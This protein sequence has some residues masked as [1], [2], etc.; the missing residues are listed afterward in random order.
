MDSKEAVAAMVA[1]HRL[2]ADALRRR[3][4]R[5]GMKFHDGS[6]EGGESRTMDLFSLGSSVIG[7]VTAAMA[8]PDLRA[9]WLAYASSPPHR[10]SREEMAWVAVDELC[11]V[12]LDWRGKLRVKPV[13]DVLKRFP[14]DGIGPLKEA[15][16][17]E[18]AK[19]GVTGE[20]GDRIA[21]DVAETV[22]SY[23]AFRFRLDVRVETVANGWPDRR[24]EGKEVAM[25]VRASA[26]IIDYSGACMASLGASSASIPDPA[27]LP[28]RV[29]ARLHAEAIDRAMADIGAPL[30]VSAAERRAAEWTNAEIELAIRANPGMAAAIGVDPK[31]VARF[32]AGYDWSRLIAAAAEKAHDRAAFWRSLDASL[33]TSASSPPNP[34][35]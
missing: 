33:T 9:K 22:L 7:P 26:D 35:P 5:A 16:K 8:D 10:R 24:R 32:K 29:A 6:L 14:A 15:L 20:K 2:A 18:L 1:D 27:S 28:P 3:Y 11:S 21:Q 19:R 12:V 17:G 23:V 31:A 34:I 30:S 13:T 25:L 4:M